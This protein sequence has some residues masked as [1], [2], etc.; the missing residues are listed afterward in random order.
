MMLPKSNKM[1]DLSHLD[2]LISGFLT[3]IIGFRGDQLTQ[4]ERLY[5]R[6][7]VRLAN[8]ALT[9]YS[10][11][12]NLVEAEINEMTR[13]SEE[14]ERDGRQLYFLGIVDH[15]ENCINATRRL[16][17]FLDVIKSEK[18]HG[19]KLRLDRLI[20]RMIE[21]QS[22]DIVNIRDC[23]EHLD[24]QIQKSEK[25]GPIMLSFSDD[26]ES[27][28]IA[29]STIRFVDLALVLKYF[30]KLSLQWLDDFCKT[31]HKRDE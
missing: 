23:I 29:D 12:R 21:A 24:E 19:G 5:I 1:P 16:F 13:S 11:A 25:F 10:V 17:H 27:I 14:M 26:D 3:A 2:P 18:R 20:R 28:E 15:M 7:F 31:P 8:K 22:R 6:V 9:E 4:K 30:H